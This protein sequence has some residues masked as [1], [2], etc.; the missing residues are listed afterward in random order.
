MLDLLT[1]G[2]P[3]VIT[4]CVHYYYCTQVYMAFVSTIDI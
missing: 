1:N 2:I 3:I 4:T